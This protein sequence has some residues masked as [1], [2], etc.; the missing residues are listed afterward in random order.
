MQFQ[1]E[2]LNE[3]FDLEWL[4]AVVDQSCRSICCSVNNVMQLISPAV[5]SE[6]DRTAYVCN[7]VCILYE[8]GTI[9]V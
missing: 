9:I 2:R 5:V 4:M 7:C 3:S 1:L 8:Y 6:A